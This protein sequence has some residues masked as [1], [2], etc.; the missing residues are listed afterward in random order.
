M[1][2]PIMLTNMSHNMECLLVERNRLQLSRAGESTRRPRLVRPRK[3]R[4][5]SNIVDPFFRLDAGQTSWIEASNGCEAT[6]GDGDRPNCSFAICLPERLV[7][8]AVPEIRIR[9][10]NC[11]DRYE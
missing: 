6:R 7:T 4:D 11:T 10:T 1:G 2:V 8:G 3:T 9:Q 5:R